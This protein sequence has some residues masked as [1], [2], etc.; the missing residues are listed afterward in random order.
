[1]PESLVIYPPVM[2]TA[3]AAE[4][5][6]VSMRTFRRILERGK[7]RYSRPSSHIKVR[8]K[9]LDAYLTSRTVGK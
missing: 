7:L 1:M 8:R 5:L 2:G 4:Y 3:L 6:G 9:D